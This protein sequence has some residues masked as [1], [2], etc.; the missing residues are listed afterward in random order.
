MPQQLLHH[1]ELGADTSQESGVRV[2]KC[3]PSE[4][5][6]NPDALRDRA[7]MLSQNCL[8][9]DWFPTT[10]PS[11]RENPVVGFGIPGAF[12]PFRECLQNCW[13]NRYGLLRCFSLARTHHSVHDGVRDVH[14][15]LRDYT[16]YRKEDHGQ[17]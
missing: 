3:M 1:F 12:F 7:D 13:M 4:L 10:V 6:L 2:S 17:P 5:F 9:P 14:C 11:A 15:A 16:G 8:A